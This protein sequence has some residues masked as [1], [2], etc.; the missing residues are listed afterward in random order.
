MFITSCVSIFEILSTS[1]PNLPSLLRSFAPNISLQGNLDPCALY[2]S[3]EEIR[4]YV[5]QMIKRFGTQRYIA[6]LGHGIYPDF[7][8]EHVGVFIDAVHEYSEKLNKDGDLWWSWKSRDLFF[9]WR[10]FLERLLNYDWLPCINKFIEVSLH[11]AGSPKPLIDV[12][13]DNLQCFMSRG[14]LATWQHGHFGM[15]HFWPGS[16]QKVASLR[17]PVD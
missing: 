15:S 6:N 2:S 14:R 10:L 13:T 5:A 8:P 4:T 16:L 7:N 17:V 12:Y 1:F 3:K 9:S 11:S